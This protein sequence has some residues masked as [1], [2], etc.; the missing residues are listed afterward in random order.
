MKAIIKCCM[1]WKVIC[2]LVLLGAALLIIAPGIGTRALPVLF[3]LACPLSMLVML[4]LM[5]KGINVDNQP[6]VQKQLDADRSP[7]SQTEKIRR[8]KTQRALLQSQHEEL[9]EQINQLESPRGPSQSHSAREVVT[10]G[11]E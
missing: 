8:L 6:P 5:V 9:V 7:V 2:G 10:P 11:A 3:M 1:N 4:P